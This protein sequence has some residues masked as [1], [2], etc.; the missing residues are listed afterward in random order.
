MAILII[1][2]D[3][4]NF[5]ARYTKAGIPLVPTI[6]Y[7][8]PLLLKVVSMKRIVKKRENTMNIVTKPPFTLLAQ[9]KQELQLTTWPTREETIKL[10]AVV[11]LVSVAVGVYLGGL[12]WILTLLLAQII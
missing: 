5:F 6:C 12:D 2:H 11:V 9:V 1:L 8:M 3:Y 7:N 10:T 4:P